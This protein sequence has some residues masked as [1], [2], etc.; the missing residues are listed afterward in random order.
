LFLEAANLLTQ[1]QVNSWH[2]NPLAVDWWPNAIQALQQAQAR[3]VT[4]V[5]DCFRDS[6][7]E[8]R[9]QIGILQNHVHL[10]TL[11]IPEVVRLLVNR[12]G[13][14]PPRVQ[15][16]LL[17]CY[18]DHEFARTINLRSDVF[19]A[20]HL[21]PQPQNLIRSTMPSPRPVSVP[22]DSTI[23]ISRHDLHAHVPAHAVR[24]MINAGVGVPN[25][26]AY[27]PREVLFGSIASWGQRV[28]GLL[29]RDNPMTSQSGP[30]DRSGPS[31]SEIARATHTSPVPIEPVTTDHSGQHAPGQG[32]APAALYQHFVRG[33]NLHTGAGWQQAVA[34]GS[35]SND[36]RSTSLLTSPVP[37][38]ASIGEIG[39]TQS[40]EPLITESSGPPMSGQGNAP[41]AHI[42]QDRMPLRN[43]L[44]SHLP[45]GWHHLDAV[46]LC[47]D[48]RL[49]INTL[50]EVPLAI[51]SHFKRIQSAVW[52][53]LVNSYRL[54]EDRN[55]NTRIRA[56]KLFTLLSRMLLFRLKRGG[57]KG[58]DELQQ[59]IRLFDEGKWDVLLQQALDTLPRRKR[60]ETLVPDS[61]EDWAARLTK[62]KLLAQRG[63]LSNAARLIRSNGLAPGDANT[64]T[65]LTN[66][67]LRTPFS[68]QDIP[69][70]ILDYV[71]S[72]ALT[73]DRDIFIR[74]LRGARRGLSGGLSGHRNEHLK[75]ALDDEAAIND[76]AEIA[77]SM[78]V[79]D[80]PDSIASAYRLCKL[81]AMRKGS[82]KIRGLNA[83]DPF[84]RLV[85]RSLA[86]QFADEFRVATSPYN[87]GLSEHSGT[88]S[89][90]HYLRARVE[91]DEELCITKVD[92]IGA[93][94]HIL[95]SV[96]LGKLRTLPNAH[97]LLPYV[98]ASYGSP[99]TYVWTDAESVIHDIHQGEGGEQGDALMPALFALGLHDALHH[100]TQ[101]LRPG[102]EIMAY[103]DDVYI[104]CKPD[105]VKEIYDLVAIDIRTHTGIALNEG[106]TECWS[107]GGGPP[108]PNVNLLNGPS[109]APP[110]WKSNLPPEQNGLEIL[111]SPIGC[112]A[113]I[114][115]ILADKLAEEDRLFDKLDHIDDLQ[116]GWLL[117]FY[118]ASP[119]ANYILRTVPPTACAEYTRHRDTR[120]REVLAN[121]F[122]LAPEILSDSAIIDQIHLPVKLGGLGLISALATRVPAYWAS[123]C[124]ALPNM[125]ERFPGFADQFMPNMM[126]LSVDS[127][128]RPVHSCLRNLHE[129]ALHL[130]NQGFSD[131]PNWH[132]LLQGSTPPNVEEDGF[133]PGERKHGW[134][135]IASQH[136][137]GL[138]HAAYL[139]SLSNT[140]Q[141]RLRSTAGPN[142]GRW[143]SAIPHDAQFQMEAPIF[144]CAVFRRLGLQVDPTG[145]Q[146]EGCGHVLDPF[147]WHRC[148]CMRSGRVQKRHKPLVAAWR[149]V[150][151]EAGV[152]I[153][154]RNIERRLATTHINRGPNDR[155][156]MDLI[157]SGI[158]GIC[159]GSALFMDATLVSPL[160]G[161]GRVMPGSHRQDG[162]ALARADHRN[163]FSDYPDVQQ[164][165]DA[166]LLCLG[167]ETYGRWGKHC[168]DLVRCLAKF[169]GRNVPDYLAKGIQQAYSA[170][171]WNL[172]SV[173]V[174]RIVSETII[175]QEGSDL[176]GAE[177]S[178]HGPPVESVLEAGW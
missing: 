167:V 57:A 111:G 83:A 68:L 73:L 59:R 41:A 151:R 119:R 142:A 146:C 27:S 92:G 135:R 10:N 86:K 171:W 52:R 66:P 131:I 159:G 67:A 49:P 15:E 61:D 98:V 110:V 74:C 76:L 29:R 148:T 58:T 124:D 112:Q 40:D 80:L 16:V 150:F 145:G 95:R 149:R 123:W 7:F 78:A 56:W 23:H 122:Q 38:A 121:I 88:E 141:A 39:P 161:N 154:D 70:E 134:Q 93:F 133:E 177:P 31:N 130:Q 103:L 109:P 173:Q 21:R 113:Y 136:C 48:M 69:Q 65:E 89:I 174:Q 162:E 176:L 77:Q 3:T 172:L 33:S 79:A 138:Q 28:A 126:Q 14:V 82:N 137:I 62:A 2:T 22:P 96:M 116:I 163:R 64:L 50:E 71:P 160:R 20:V 175:R 99:S 100:I 143:L 107:P 11:T 153:P 13:Y 87:F 128:S 166:A 165:P 81:T 94:D 178:S 105:R 9:A 47:T 152:V 17:Q 43:P 18:L 155:R 102:E 42:P 108:P 125:M 6:A 85:S 26:T 164:S 168:L 91:Q 37:T 8:C 24:E 147:G 129:A 36:R 35:V 63:E 4:D 120:I 84:K 5:I 170:R 51:R 44:S 106:K 32:S 72:E 46:D 144:R 34:E 54:A 127:H 140:D 53:N 114:D 45:N 118:C 75:V 19:R 12:N 157:T 30:I 1:D 25:Q 97:K 158:D 55:D 60:R 169:K 117:L 139:G 101:Q 156:R 104:V 115:R 90:I 132:D